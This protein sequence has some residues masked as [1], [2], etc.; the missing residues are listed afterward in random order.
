MN[1][2]WLKDF[3]DDEVAVSED[4][5]EVMQAFRGSRPTS[6]LRFD[7]SWPTQ[8]HGCDLSQSSAR[9][10]IPRLQFTPR[11]SAIRLAELAEVDVA[12]ELALGQLQPRLQFAQLR[13][14][15]APASRLA[16]VA[17]RDRGTSG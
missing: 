6:A 13:L 15:L 2:V 14:D 8:R 3:L 12:A 5:Y 4:L 10:L 16:V 1:F 7:C 17:L 11:P 9:G